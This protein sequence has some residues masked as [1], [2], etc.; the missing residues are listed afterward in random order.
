MRKNLAQLQE[1]MRLRNLR[2]QEAQKF[3]A[4]DQINIVNE[5]RQVCSSCNRRIARRGSILCSRCT[6]KGMENNLRSTLPGMEIEKLDEFVPVEQEQVDIEGKTYT[7]RE[8]AQIVGVSPTS[9]IRWERKGVVPFPIKIAHSNKCVYTEDNL[10]AIKAY[11]EQVI[12]T[13]YVPADPKSPQELAAK[14]VSQKTFKINKRLE[15]V[16]SRAI[17]SSSYRGTGRLM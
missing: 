11:K 6:A 15:R 10:N 7:R 17:T 14:Q 9:I 12:H 3:L 2:E 5:K 4:V 13:Q 8:V 1:E 16:V